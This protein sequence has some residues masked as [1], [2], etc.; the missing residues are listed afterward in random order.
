MRAE[1]R[2]GAC[3]EFAAKHPV[4]KHVPSNWRACAHPSPLQEKKER[5][6]LLGMTTHTC[7][8]ST[9]VLSFV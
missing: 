3:V 9:S 4:C 8:F 5:Y 2:A 7:V 6:I 1:Q